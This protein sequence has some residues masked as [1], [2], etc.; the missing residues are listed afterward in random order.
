MK[1]FFST[2]R[3]QIFAFGCELMGGNLPSLRTRWCVIEETLPW[4]LVILCGTCFSPCPP[5]AFSAATHAYPL[6]PSCS[7]QRQ[8][9]SG[10]RCGEKVRT[11]V[12]SGKAFVSTRHRSWKVVGKKACSRSF[13]ESLPLISLFRIREARRTLNFWIA[14]FKDLSAGMI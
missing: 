14:M 10:E 6:Y 12:H 5:S 1:T 8:E 11:F 2:G 7:A 3:M 13:V 9:A 4:N